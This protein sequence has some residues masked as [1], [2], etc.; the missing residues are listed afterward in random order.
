M[1]REHQG[2]THEVIVVPG[3]FSWRDKTHPSLSAIAKGI[4][5]TSWNG[6]SRQALIAAVPRTAR[7][8]D[9]FRE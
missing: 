9:S 1:V 8:A 4:T 5:G 3:G 6:P 2:A 7:S